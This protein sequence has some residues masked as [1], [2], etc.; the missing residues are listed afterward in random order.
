V[1]SVPCWASVRIGFNTWSIASLPYQEFIPGLADIGY[2]AIAISVVPG[3]TIGGQ[4]VANATDQDC[5][6]ADDRRRIKHAVQERGLVLPSIVAN[7]SLVHDD[8]DRNAAA[9]ARLRASID[10]CVE[11]TPVDQP[12]A[13]LNTGIAGRS[14]ELEAKQQLVLDRLGELT[15]YARHKGVV[16]CIEPHV[17]G[18]V[19]SIA[20]AEWLVRTVNSPHCRLDFD[21]S[22][23]EVQG[24]PAT[25]TVPRLAPLAGAAE[26][27]DQ[28]ISPPGGADW[29]IAGN[30][31]GETLAPDGQPL[32]Y[33]FLLGGEGDFDLAEYLRLMQAHGFSEPISFEA[34][35]QC[36]ARPGY[37]GLAA[38]ASTYQWMR[39]GWQRANMPIS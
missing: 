1:A 35:V 22:H 27:K 9:M 14:G 4:Y 11:L 24:V 34:S 3:Y 2:T 23:F 38:A 37:D 16:V 36:Q 26:I 20:R 29:K 5:L 18:A 8:P 31:T 32:E 13:G 7:Q 6:T 25:Q 17:G 19:D 39:A 15:E 30:G 12:V 10:L 21:V 28:R 33:Q